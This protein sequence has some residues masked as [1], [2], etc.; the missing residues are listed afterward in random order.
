MDKLNQT[1]TQLAKQ[2]N[3]TDPEINESYILTPEEEEESI[4]YAA[5]KLK[6]NTVWKMKDKGLSEGEILLRISGVNWES[7]VNREEILKAANSSKHQDLWHKEQR[8][9]EKEAEEKRIKDLVER[10]DAKYMW[11]L[12]KWTSKEKYKKDFILNSENKHFV[13]CLCYFLSG[14]PRFETELGYSFQKGLLIRGVSGLG[15]THLVQ[16][17]ADNELNPILILSMLDITDEIKHNGEYEIKMGNKKVIYLDDVGTEEPTVNHYGTKISYFKNFIELVYLKNQGKTF[18]KLMVSTN[19]SFSEMEEKY[20]FRVR[21]RIKDM[22][23]IIDVKGK[24][25]RG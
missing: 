18:N 17:V 16:C 22:F 23:N 11:K 1:L 10:C 12:M 9:K 4:R 8:V 3:L 19:N 24:D 20:G 6:E 21:S 13:T 7:E 5:Q 15:K 2:L 25:M 14:D